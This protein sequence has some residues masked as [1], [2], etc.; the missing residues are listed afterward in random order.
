MR[1]AANQGRTCGVSKFNSAGN[2]RVTWIAAPGIEISGVLENCAADFWG[3]VQTE[4]SV[5]EALYRE[6]SDGGRSEALASFPAGYRACL[7]SRGADPASPKA[8][9][10]KIHIILGNELS[11]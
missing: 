10:K 8:K 3:Y 4:V 2:F 6:I 5:C 11:H 7:G 1:L 9:P